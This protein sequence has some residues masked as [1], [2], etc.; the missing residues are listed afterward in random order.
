M[1]TRTTKNKSA[2]FYFFTITCFRW[3]PF[4]E[5]TNFYEE[6]F[7]WYEILK[8]NKTHLVAYVI[9]PNHLHAVVY[10]DNNRTSINKV[11]S[12]G[13]RFMAYEIVKRLSDMKKVNLL[14]F[15]EKNVNERERMTGKIHQVFEPSFDLKELFS[16]KFVF[17]KI[18]YLHLN[19][20]RKKWRLCD[21]FLDYKYSSARFYEGL[22]YS[23]Y[24]VSHYLDFVK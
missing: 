24:P 20:V 5:I 16:E 2:V 11:I 12:N 6:I 8:N 19:P 23:G 4:F 7:K 22:F 10:Y 14:Y 13:K 9:M 18:Q 21:T 15:L 1:S 3:L 17:Q